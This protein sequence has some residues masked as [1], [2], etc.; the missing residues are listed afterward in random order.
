M[1]LTNHGENALL[2]LFK[3]DGPY[4]L[5]LFTAAPSE[6]GGG[7]EISGGGYARQAV[8]FG[9]PANGSMTNSAAIEF[10]T[11]T[12]SW[13]TAKAWG[14]FDAATSGNLVWYGNIDTPK[15]LLAGDIYRI[16]AGNLTLTMD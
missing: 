11:A 9:T 5:A 6:T 12:A 3:N 14:L 10:P 2:T 16:N 7:T 15:E 1:S 4:Y 13:G 8:T